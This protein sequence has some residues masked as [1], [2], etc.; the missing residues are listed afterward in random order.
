M[1][2][3]FRL[4]GAWLGGTTPHARATIQFLQINDPAAVAVREGLIEE[5][6]LD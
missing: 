4:K 2:R 6:P 1:G 3:T 5:G